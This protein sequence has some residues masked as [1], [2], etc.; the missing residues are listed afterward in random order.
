MS[1]PFRIE[2]AGLFNNVWAWVLALTPWVLTFLMFLALYK[3]TPGLVV[4][5]RAAAWGAVFSTVVWELAKIAFA[6]YLSSGL[7]RFDVLYGSLSTIS[8][9]HVLDLYQRDGDDFWSAF[10]RID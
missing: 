10:V 7:S 3:W 2:Y 9:R 5:W 4:K 6:W 1:L 8:G